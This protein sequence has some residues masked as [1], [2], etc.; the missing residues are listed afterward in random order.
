[1]RDVRENLKEVLT[2]NTAAHE[3]YAWASGRYNAEPGFAS[4]IDHGAAGIMALFEDYLIEIGQQSR[5]YEKGEEIP[6]RLK[7]MA[8]T[9]RDILLLT[10]GTI[11]QRE[12]HVVHAN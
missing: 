1:M 9:V 7:A 11:E 2:H 10:Q 4:A 12:S 3:I 8:A 5:L 6:E